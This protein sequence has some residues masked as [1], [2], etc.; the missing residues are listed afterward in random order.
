MSS[1]YMHPVY[2]HFLKTRLNCPWV[3]VRECV[4]V[5][6]LISDRRDQLGISKNEVLS[7]LPVS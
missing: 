3:T 6:D 5:F 1:I 4:I 2:C 7:N